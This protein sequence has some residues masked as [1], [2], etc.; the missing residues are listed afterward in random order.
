MPK[1]DLQDELDGLLVSMASLSHGLEQVLGR[2]AAP[3]TFRAGRAVGLKADIQKKEKDT[4]AA[5]QMLNMSSCHKESS[6]R[7]SHGSQHPHRPI[8][9]TRTGKQRSVSYFVTA[10]FGVHCFAIATTRRC[11]CA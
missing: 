7:S 8:I 9:M 10:W 3:V 5:L 2:G 4:L 11:R 6:G 1:K